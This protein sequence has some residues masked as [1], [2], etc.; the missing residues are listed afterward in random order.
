MP[1]FGIFSARADG[2]TTVSVGLAAVLSQSSRTLLID[3]NLQLSEVAALLD[4]DSSRNLFHLAYNAQLA[5]VDG[6]DLEG[7]LSWRDG[8][9]VL[10]GIRKP[11]HAESISD[12][13]ISGLLEAA[14]KRFDNVVLDLGRVRDELPA[15]VSSGQLLWVVS[16][17]P[18]GMDALDR[19]YWQL[20]DAGPSW[21]Q[22]ARIVLNRVNESSLVGTDRYIEREYELKVAGTI[23]DTPDFWRRVDLQHS[24]RALNASDPKHPRYRKTHGEQALLAR[25]AFEQ[26]AEALTTTK[27]RTP[28]PVLTA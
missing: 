4:L 28:E 13:F 17:T 7:H 18:L 5:P 23:P 16:P 6:D 10:P 1:V 15:A 20:D 21:L 3:L 9:G 27:E 19:R 26:L 14:T 22:S 11:E 24:P 2:A 25:Q 12:H 8:I